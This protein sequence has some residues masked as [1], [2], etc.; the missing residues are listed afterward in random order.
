MVLRSMESNMQWKSDTY[1]Y[2]RLI[3]AQTGTEIGSD[4]RPRAQRVQ[5]AILTG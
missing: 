3:L 4:E 5:R 1:L 2:F